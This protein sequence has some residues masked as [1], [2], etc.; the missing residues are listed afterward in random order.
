LL[1]Y[2][3]EKVRILEDVLAEHEVKADDIVKARSECEG[4]GEGK[5]NLRTMMRGAF[6][7]SY[8]TYWIES[9]RSMSR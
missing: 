3:F 2:H 4:E 1:A 5:R 8:R 9:K 6:A 7:L